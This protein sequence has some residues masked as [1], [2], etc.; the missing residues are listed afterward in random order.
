MAMN[1]PTCGRGDAYYEASTDFTCNDPWH[2]DAHLRRK[3]RIE[4]AGLNPRARVNQTLETGPDTLRKAA[5]VHNATTIRMRAEHSRA[6][7]EQH[8]AV[9]VQRWAPV[10]PWER[11]NFQRDLMMLF[12]DAMRHQAGTFGLHIERTEMTLDALAM[13]STGALQAVYEADD[14]HQ[15]RMKREKAF[16]IARNITNQ[17]KKEG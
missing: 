1:C 15:I 9:F 17:L 2:A 12:H 6:C 11:D 13:Q 8:L 3:G 14:P 16:E 4:A 5:D 10:G 7:F